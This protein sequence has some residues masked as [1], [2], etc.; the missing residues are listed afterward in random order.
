[1]DGSE[2]TSHEHKIHILTNYYKQLLGNEFQ[3]TWNFPL[4]SIY[5]SHTLGLDCLMAPLSENEIVDSFF[6][7]NMNASP[8]SDG[9]GPSFY[10]KFWKLTKQRILRMFD[11]FYNLSLDTSSIN[12]AHLLL[13]PKSD[14]A[15]SPDQFRPLSLQN[16]LIESI[17]KL[18]FPP[19]RNKCRGLSTN[20]GLS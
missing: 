17:A 3:S 8:G 16:C 7:M 18:I 15:R 11:Q 1:V 13:I 4:L 9:F 2:Y 14:G 12:R 6:H 10:R 19:I 5:P 20:F